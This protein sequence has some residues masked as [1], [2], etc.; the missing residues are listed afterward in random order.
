MMKKV[1]KPKNGPKFGE[2]WDVRLEKKEESKV[3][4]DEDVV[5]MVDGVDDDM[6][7]EEVAL[8]DN[9]SQKNDQLGLCFGGDPGAHSVVDVFNSSLRVNHKKIEKK[10]K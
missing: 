10:E 5:F 3:D 6:E 1:P 9:K 8:Y 7:F 4:A 2:T